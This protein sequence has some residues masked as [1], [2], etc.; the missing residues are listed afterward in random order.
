MDLKS[1]EIYHSFH[2]MIFYF[3][4][5]GDRR[6]R[7]SRLKRLQRG[8]ISEDEQL[9]PNEINVFPESADTEGKVYIFLKQNYIEI[10]LI[11]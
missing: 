10:F 4:G 9:D 5:D 7:L 1:Q 11:E 6:R 8:D 2:Y 3:Q